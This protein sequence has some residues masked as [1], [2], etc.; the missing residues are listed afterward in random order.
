MVHVVILGGGFGAVYTAKRLQPYLKRHPEHTLTLIAKQPTFIF[1]P[2]LH[3]VAVGIIDP[4]V[5]Q[6]GLHT[7]LSLSQIMYLFRSQ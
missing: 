4:E 7:L 5:I 1:S 3:E 2:L 6:V